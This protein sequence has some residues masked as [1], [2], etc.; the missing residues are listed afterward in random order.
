MYTPF[1][2]FYKRCIVFLIIFMML[3]FS[4]QIIFKLQKKSLS[5]K[6]R[7]PPH[8]CDDYAEQYQ[9]RRNQW[10]VDAIHEYQ[11]NNKALETSNEVFFNGPM[12]CF[13]KS[14]QASGH[15]SSEVYSL[16]DYKTGESFSKP[17]CRNFFIDMLVAKIFGQ[18]ISFI[19]IG[20]NVILKYTIMYLVY[21]IGEETAS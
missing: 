10:M 3:Y 1:Q 19:V 14:E 12:Q 4:F 15:Y 6:D 7:Y 21:W 20:I 5:M 17:I 13:C 8:S 9:G 18:S 16:T 11:T 2:R